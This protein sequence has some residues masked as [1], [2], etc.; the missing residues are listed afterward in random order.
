[1]MIKII[2]Y[3]KKANI[4]RVVIDDIII[5]KYK[6]RLFYKIRE[7]ARARHSIS[8]PTFGFLFFFASEQ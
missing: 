8:S 6:I 4:Y 5:Y 1:M 7:T 3:D 2:I